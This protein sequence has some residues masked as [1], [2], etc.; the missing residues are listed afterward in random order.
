VSFIR[1]FN[2]AILLGDRLGIALYGMFVE[3]YLSN[4]LGI[5]KEIY[6]KFISGFPCEIKEHTPENFKKLIDSILKYGFQENNP[7]FCNP[8]EYSLLNG[9]HRCAIAFQLGIKKVPYVLR[10]CDNYVD[11]Q[12]I[13]KLLGKNFYD[14]VVAKRLEYI[15]RCE[16]MIALKCKL[17]IHI[18]K[19]KESFLA[20][21]S[22]STK[23]P[24]LRTYQAYESLQIKGKRPAQLRAEIYEVSKYLT[25]NMN[26]LEI[27]C[28]VGFFSLV[29][30]DFVRSVMAFDVD[31]N[32][33]KVAEI[34]RSFCKIENC[35]FSTISVLDF[36][37]GECFDCVISTAIHGW[38]KLPFNSYMEKITGWLIPGGI[39]I[40]ESHELDVEK[41]WPEKRN[42]I[43]KN[44]DILS[45]GIIDD[46][47]TNLYQSEYREYLILRKRYNYNYTGLP[48]ENASD[49]NDLVS[50]RSNWKSEIVSAS[51]SFNS[52]I[53]NLIKSIFML[54][55]SFTPPFARSQIK[56]IVRLFNKNPRSKLRDI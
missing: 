23:I 26:V 50:L 9:S 24:A 20:P 42:F 6:N 43:A 38:T 14:K 52:S 27:G 55:K 8:D 37:A 4:N 12:D 3:A 25:S 49:P 10:Y 46:I 39:L 56:K 5:E 35:N 53:K 18:R 1:T 17:R 33:I 34:V 47:D 19:H 15:N 48:F 31:N 30:S 41:S 29:I 7:V 40:F 45:S 11:E 2:P 54:L 16:P 51:Y 44:F 32:Y 28:N 13:E 21:F 22:S 36:K